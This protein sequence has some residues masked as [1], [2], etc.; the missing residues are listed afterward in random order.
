MKR[1]HLNKRMLRKQ[2]YIKFPNLDFFQPLVAFQ[3]T[4]VQRFNTDPCGLVSDVGW[5]KPAPFFIIKFA[6]LSMHFMIERLRPH[7]MYC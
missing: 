3:I 2:D 4:E 6:L 1:M 5:F 7:D